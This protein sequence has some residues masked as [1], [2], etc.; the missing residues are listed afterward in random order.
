LCPG[1]VDHYT[2]RGSR[3]VRLSGRAAFSGL[4]GPIYLF[5]RTD[6]AKF[7]NRSNEFEA[8][9]MAMVRGDVD[10]VDAWVF[11]P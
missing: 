9:L 1:I 11:V 2:Q 10:G 7:G 4:W 6:S 3:G 5:M 8:Q